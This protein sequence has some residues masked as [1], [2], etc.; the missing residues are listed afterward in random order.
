MKR[1]KKYLIQD[2]K[3][4]LLEVLRDPCNRLLKFYMNN[5]R[6]SFDITHELL[7]CSRSLKDS[8][9]YR[10]KNIL[11]DQKINEQINNYIYQK[12]NELAGLVLTVVYKY[13]ICNKK[14][15]KNDKAIKKFIDYINKNNYLFVLEYIPKFGKLSIKD[16]MSMISYHEICFDL[17]SYVY[18]VGARGIKQ[19]IQYLM[20]CLKTYSLDQTYQEL[21]E[22]IATEKY[23][24][25][26][27]QIMS[28]NNEF[29]G[30]QNKKYSLIDFLTQSYRESVK[31]YGK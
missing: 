6:N 25:K 28:V 24:E 14:I 20:D 30:D 27:F 18:V 3:D 1:S 7:I 21:Y 17:N 4:N 22:K 12:R 26:Y 23:H 9:S 31:R 11:L 16:F 8:T 10:Y 29:D 13:L 2:F 19:E 5:N 15:L